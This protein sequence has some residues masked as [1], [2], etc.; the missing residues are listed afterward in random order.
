MVRATVPAVA[1]RSA[2]ARRTAGGALSGVAKDLESTSP[3]AGVQDVARDR[4]FTVFLTADQLQELTGYRQAAAQIRWLKRQGITHYVR[5]DGHPVVPISALSE[6]RSQP[7]ARPN[8]AAI[9]T[10]R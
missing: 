4:G 1:S 7:R 6:E 5:A 10:A 3:I 2:R 8:F 9:R